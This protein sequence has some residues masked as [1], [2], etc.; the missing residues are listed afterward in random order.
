[1]HVCARDFAGTIPGRDDLVAT[2]LVGHDTSALFITTSV[3]EG[4]SAYFTV[5]GRH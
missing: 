4:V 3:K 5:T 2:R 1:M